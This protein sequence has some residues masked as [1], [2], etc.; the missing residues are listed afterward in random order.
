MC[1]WASR[2]DLAQW[3][4]VPTRENAILDH[5]YTR[6]IVPRDVAIIEKSISDHRGIK[7]TI[8]KKSSK[9]KMISYL[10]LQPGNVKNIHLK[11]RSF[12]EM[13]SEVSELQNELRLA[14]ESLRITRS[15]DANP[16]M[17]W[18]RD[19]RICY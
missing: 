9:T 14:Q 1:E 15:V 6:N 11:P 13:E 12:V 4:K 10:N 7:V 18:R 8:G 3:I 19:P 17:K 2:N 16:K 5:I